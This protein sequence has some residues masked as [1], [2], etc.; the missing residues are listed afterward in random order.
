MQDKRV[1]SLFM[2]MD[3]EVHDNAQTG[4]TE[5]VHEPNE[6][7]DV[8]LTPNS[9]LLL[10]KYVEKMVK[11]N[12][13]F[14]SQEKKYRMT[15]SEVNLTSLKKEK[16][17]I[18]ASNKEIVA[19]E[20]KPNNSKETIIQL[21][22]E[23][24]NISSL[25]KENKKTAMLDTMRDREKNAIPTHEQ[26]VLLQRDCDSTSESNE[27]TAQL[28][29]RDDSIPV[30]NEAIASLQGGSD[31]RPEW[32]KKLS[33]LQTS[34]QKESDSTPEWKK[35]LSALHTEL[36][37]I[38][39]SK[40]RVLTIEKE[41]ST[42]PFF[43][44]DKDLNKD[45]VSGK[46]ERNSISKLKQEIS[47]SC[48]ENDSML[49]AN[50]EIASS[51]DK[52]KFIRVDTIV[53]ALQMKNENMPMLDEKIALVK[54]ESIALDLVVKV[55]KEE[56]TI[57][58]LSKKIALLEEE[59][60]SIPILNS[61]VTALQ[62]ENEV[63]P[64]LRE[65]IN[66]CREKQREWS[67]KIATLNEACNTIKRK[68]C[69]IPVLKKTI[70]TLRKDMEVIPTLTEKLKSI[71]KLINPEACSEVDNPSSTKNS[72]IDQA[73]KYELIIKQKIECTRKKLKD[74]SAQVEKTSLISA[75][76]ETLLQKF[77]VTDSSSLAQWRKMRTDLN[78]MESNESITQ[79]LKKNSALSEERRIVEFERKLYDSENFD[80]RMKGNVI[81]SDGGKSCRKQLRCKGKG[82]HNPLEQRAKN[83]KA[84]KSMTFKSITG[85]NKERRM[86]P[87]V[88]GNANPINQ[89]IELFLECFGDDTAPR[90]RKNQAKA[91]NIITPSYC[92]SKEECSKRQSDRYL[93]KIL[94]MASS[95]K[96]FDDHS[97][98]MIEIK[99]SLLEE[100][101]EEYRKQEN[102]P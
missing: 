90:C 1:E 92:E 19:L 36:T 25:E 29:K 63:I 34:M 22:K 13:K 18:L 89:Q 53:Q 96:N 72:F 57:V 5:V 33:A 48:G 70:L 65:E 21:Y 51:H 101:K 77:T 73:E 52:K 58:L 97:P 54:Q 85:V 2:L 24:K 81:F 59:N 14:S 42:L 11:T 44:A 94:E 3:Y 32:K 6:E 27:V 86:V 56:E 47:S 43:M 76:Q 23:M 100:D 17:C 61:K 60:D 30:V 75:Q 50:E 83:K 102:M 38:R 20:N 28:Q 39:D 78:T 15:L 37:F 80:K 98:W 99:K 16:D 84:E 66:L 49:C 41:N 26:L 45:L 79:K 12:E 55:R 9:I 62:K 31:S 82:V 93:M 69:I 40:V 88:E 95:N 8:E 46:S 68:N 10:E 4:N 71:A 91:G 64:T 35:K 67:L 87:R 74:F 7:N